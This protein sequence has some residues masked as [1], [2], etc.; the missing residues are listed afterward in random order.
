MAK[1]ETSLGT[2]LYEKTVSN[3][4]LLERLDMALNLA[5]EVEKMSEFGIERTVHRDLK[6]TNIMLDAAR[7]FI[8]IDFGIGRTYDPVND[9]PSWGSSGTPAFVAPEQLTCFKQNEKV[10]VWA[11]GKVIA[12][13][14]FEWSCG[15]HLLWSPKFLTPDEIRS[16]GPLVQLID[17][18]KDMIA[19]SYHY[20][21]CYS[22]DIFIHMEI[23]TSL[24]IIFRF[25]LNPDERP[26][27]Q[28]VID[29]IESVKSNVMSDQSVH[30]R[31]QNAWESL[32]TKIT[33]RNISV[34]RN[35]MATRNMVKEVTVM[36][37]NARSGPNIPDETGLHFQKMSNLCTQF[38]I[39]SA[40]RHEMK[41]IIKNSISTAVNMLNGFPTDKVSIPIP[42]GKLIDE[43]FKEN[44][45]QFFN[46][47]KI[48]IVDYPNAL[49][50]ERMLSVLLGCVSPRP[51][52][53]LVKTFNIHFEIIIF[54]K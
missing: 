12:L 4:N 33:K 41:K 28:I 46:R 18:L 31:V 43:L 17:L 35:T 23:L 16:L 52:S 37:L 32:H 13:I 48:E 21:Y 49:S 42:A 44:E 14:I 26:N 7:S 9:F 30:A 36:D 53:G 34:S 19:V 40:V 50:F 10:D 6:P 15:W 3:F 11:L 47:S 22:S 39:M 54:F 8:L 25:K 1:F 38:A 51:L 24:I 20:A 27:V 45:F 2:F 5:K 29:K